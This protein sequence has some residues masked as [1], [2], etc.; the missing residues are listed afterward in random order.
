MAEKYAKHFQQILLIGIFIII[1][2]QINMNLF[3][4]NFRIS[5]GTLIFP[6]TFVMFGKY[7]VLPVTF[8]SAVGVLTSRVLSEW[9][10]YD[11]I[12]FY[13]FFPEMIFYLVYG[14]LF[15]IY[16]HKKET[17]SPD[18]AAVLFI[19]DYISNLTELLVRLGAGAFNIKSQFGILLVAFSRSLIIYGILFCLHH[20]KFS[21]LRREHALRYQRLLLLIS[22]LNGEVVWMKK[23]TGLIEE[24]MNT[25]YQ[26][27]REL[28]E[29]GTDETLSRKALGVAK[30]IHEIKKEYLLILR[31]LSEALDLNLKDEGMYLTDILTV[32]KQSLTTESSDKKADISFQIQENLY[33]ENH[34]FL[35]SV[36]RNLLT[37]AIEASEKDNPQIH[38]IQSTDADSYLFDVTDDGPGI[39][40]EDLEQIFSPGFSTK[41]NFTTG[42]ISRG[43]G[44]NLVQDLIKNQWN[45]EIQVSSVPGCTTFHIR[46]PKSDWR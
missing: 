39:L 36:F 45:G 34:Y 43:L 24:T 15:Y 7:P 16:S 44:L 41:I 6:I 18:C 17:L 35:M 13:S 3:I 27:Y 12:Q 19:F 30:D 1:G 28:E 9:L 29:N 23:N 11:Q 25:S 10:R 40:P 22:K 31:G 5:I 2:A 32:L 46:I 21:L 14:T 20:Y 38:V 42:E 4:D 33:T 37:N 8:I 26:L